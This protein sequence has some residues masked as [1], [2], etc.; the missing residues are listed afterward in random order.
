[1]S[2]FFTLIRGF[3]NGR[4]HGGRA[5]RSRVL[6][7]LVGVTACLVVGVFVFSARPGYIADGAIVR[8]LQFE[9]V[10]SATESPI[11]GAIVAVWDSRGTGLE[12]P[13]M[14][15]GEDATRGATDENGAVTLECRLPWSLHQ[16]GLSTDEVVGIPDAF[17][18]VVDLAGYDTQRL[19]LNELVGRKHRPGDWPLPP[20][21]VVLS[22]KKHPSANDG[23]P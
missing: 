5:T 18:V 20:I 14:A 17:W 10:D 4:L 22:G 9:I 1:M 15:I 2:T 21:R 3:A 19:P 6:V 7:I 12:S 8:P 16:Q 11:A 23:Q 13:P